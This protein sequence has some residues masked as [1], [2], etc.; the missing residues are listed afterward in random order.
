[1]DTRHDAQTTSSII[2]TSHWRSSPPTCK[3]TP[4]PPVPP[5]TREPLPLRRRTDASPARLP[6]RR[7]T[8]AVRV[9]AWLVALNLKACNQFRLYDGKAAEAELAP[10]TKEA[11]PLMSTHE[12][13]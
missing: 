11:R 13:S 3:R 5:H 7:V 6:L 8:A 12:H 1:M 9:A 2:T 4:T 10:L